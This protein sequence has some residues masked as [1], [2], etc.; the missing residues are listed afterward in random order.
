MHGCHVGCSRAGQESQHA[1]S[2]KNKSRHPICIMRTD[3]AVLGA[4]WSP[5][6]DMHGCMLHALPSLG[7]PPC[8]LR[9]PSKGGKSFWGMGLALCQHSCRGGPANWSGCAETCQKVA[10]LAPDFSLFG[11]SC[12]QQSLSDPKSSQQV[13]D[14]H[15]RS[16]MMLRL[17]PACMLGSSQPPGH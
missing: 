5:G 4:L 1:V 15:K 17:L 2:I 6:C 11:S 13:S 10:I 3:I 8:S 9:W 16:Y 7:K 14:M 12:C